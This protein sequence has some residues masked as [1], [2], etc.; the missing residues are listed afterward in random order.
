MS[1]ESPSTIIHEVL[2][3]N[4]E[5][6]NLLMHEFKSI[7]PSQI[8]AVVDYDGTVSPLYMNSWDT[9]KLNDATWSNQANGLRESFTHGAITEEEFWQ[10]SLSRLNENGFRDSVDNLENTCLPIRNGIPQLF[11]ACS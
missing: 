10:Q 8:A 1:Q 5:R 6:V 7:D 11:Q 3:G 4:Q 2:I 9:P